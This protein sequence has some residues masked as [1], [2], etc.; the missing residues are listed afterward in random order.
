[1]EPHR[2]YDAYRELLAEGAELSGDG[3]RLPNRRLA[4]WALDRH[5]IAF[6]D[7]RAGALR[8]LSADEQLLLDSP[9]PR[10]AGTVGAP[11]ATRPQT[12]PIAE[13][14]E[15]IERLA[16]QRRAER[17]RRAIGRLGREPSGRSVGPPGD[18]AS[19]R[20][21]ARPPWRG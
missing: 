15:R 8:P 12:G 3:M 17:N 4:L 16:R 5:P 11:Q 6:G 14:R 9:P 20:R 10:P 21:D 18:A 1:M 19:S 7:I 2:A 13:T